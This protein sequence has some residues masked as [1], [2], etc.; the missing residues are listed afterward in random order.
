MLPI[1]CIVFTFHTFNM[2]AT[3][4]KPWLGEAVITFFTYLRKKFALFLLL[5]CF[6]RENLKLG[7]GCFFGELFD[8][9]LFLVAIL[10]VL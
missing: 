3:V 5:L 10:C 2:L 9:F 8:C 1:L 6:M 4:I 7:A